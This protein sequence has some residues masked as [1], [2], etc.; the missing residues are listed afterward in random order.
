MQE[1]TFYDTHPFDWT[2]NY[3]LH[4]VNSTLAPALASFIRDIPFGAQVLDVGCGPGRVMSCLAARGLRCTGVDLS[5]ASI[6]LMVER[7]GKPGIVASN[8]QLP[9]PDGS[10]ERV[11]SDGVIH[12]T[13]NP[14]LAFGECCRIL[15]PEGLFYLA[16]YKPGGRYQQLY[17]FPGLAIRH[18]T[19]H[20]IGK[21]LV[22]S[23][24]VPIYYAVHFAKSQGKTSW[25]GAKN[26]FYDYFVNPSVEFLSRDQIEQWSGACGVEVVDYDSNPKL[27][28]HSFLLR[29]QAPTE[30]GLGNA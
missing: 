10:I 2:G 17:R 3:R 24:M 1:T 19:S 27:N 12:H 30:S 11:I 13:S 26:L 20:W 16:V 14:L 22:H 23:T 6:E 21:A 29:K 8:L 18:L 28:V 9:F 7:T 5:P 15:R 4:E 25:R